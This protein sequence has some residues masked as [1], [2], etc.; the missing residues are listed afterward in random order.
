MALKSFNAGVPL[1]LVKITPFDVYMH[2][3]CCCVNLRVSVYLHVCM[4]IYTVIVKS[5]GLYI[6]AYW[7]C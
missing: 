7:L 4:I 5:I 2:T 6:D 1:A 3:Y